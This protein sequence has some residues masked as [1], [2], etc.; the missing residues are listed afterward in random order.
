MIVGSGAQHHNRHTIYASA[1]GGLHHIHSKDEEDA[2]IVVDHI[3][4]RAFAEMSG[5]IATDVVHV[6]RGGC[7]FGSECELSKGAAVEVVVVVVG[8]VLAKHLGR[9]GETEPRGP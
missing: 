1:N 4:R 3:V 9:Y 5:H 8:R 2:E 6:V 7:C